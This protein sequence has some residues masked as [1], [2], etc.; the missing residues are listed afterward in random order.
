[1][2]LTPPE[3]NGE[4]YDNVSLNDQGNICQELDIAT[5]IPKKCS[6]RSIKQAGQE[7]AAWTFLRMIAQQNIKLD[8]LRAV[9]KIQT[10]WWAPNRYIF[11]T[12]PKFI[13]DINFPEKFHP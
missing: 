5:M 6:V 13:K 7:E 9:H 10:G 3:L 4:S 1:M 2:R 11:I 8:E 12:L